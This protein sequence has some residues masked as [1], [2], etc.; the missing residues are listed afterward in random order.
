MPSTKQAR[1]TAAEQSVTERKERNTLMAESGGKMSSEDMSSAPIMRMP[2]TTV[3]A[4]STGTIFIAL[5][6]NKK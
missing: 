6:Y 3:T 1:D 2:S 5:R 4:V